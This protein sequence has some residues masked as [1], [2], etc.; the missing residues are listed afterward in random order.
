MVERIT[1]GQTVVAVIIRP[2]DAGHGIEFFTPGD[3]PLQVGRISRPE[4]F[5]VEP[6]LHRPLARSVTITQ[7][8]LVVQQGRVRIDFYDEWQTFLESRELSAGDVVLL[9][10]GGHGLTVLEEA[11]ILEVKQGPYL[12]DEEKIRFGSSNGG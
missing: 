7:E 5:E 12:G 1:D 10:S 9:A 8:V 4:G 2:A 6:H 3:F 11:R